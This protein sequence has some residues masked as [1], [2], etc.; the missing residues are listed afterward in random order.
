MSAIH[1]TLSGLLAAILLGSLQAETRTWKSADGA[2]TFEG[3]L[4]S[5]ESNNVTVRRG[6]GKI[7]TFDIA[8]LSEDD[9]KWLENSGKEA[10]TAP[11]DAAAAPADAVFD[12]LCFGD[13][14]KTVEAKL[15]AST[16][17]E[18]TVDDTFLGRFGLNGSFR[19]KQKIGGLYCELFFDWTSGGG[20]KEISLQTQPQES[21]TYDNELRTNWD[22]FSKLMT[23]LHGKPLQR[24]G[25]PD[26]DHLENEAFL[27]SHLWRLKG[28]GSA[29]L[30]TAM[31]ANKY[32]V[33]VR[34]TTENV[35]PNRV[36]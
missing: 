22:E 28:G 23:T 35:K 36:P 19:T 6:D 21:T 12:T 3:E 11:A 8:K 5:H 13:N 27:G 25:Y 17:V 16:M 4:V 24:A 7:F 32:M 33:V 34:F 31:Q 15:K 10:A 2:A 30:G 14:R 18:S 26:C 9:R 1:P 29:M 20:L